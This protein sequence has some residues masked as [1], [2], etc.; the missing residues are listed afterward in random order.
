MFHCTGG[1]LS[2]TGRVW[3]AALWAMPRAAVTG[4]TAAWW[5][6][7]VAD[8][9]DEVEVTVARNRQPGGRPGVRVRRRDLA[10]ADLVLSQFLLVSDVPLT[11]LEAAVQLDADG[12]EF[13]DRALQR[14]VRFEALSRAHHRNLG[15]HGSPAAAALLGAAADGAASLAE[16]RL[17]GLLRARGLTG[18][19]LGYA[20]SGYLLDLAFPAARVAVEVDGWA[21]HSTADRFRADRRRQNAL[22]LAGW[23]VLRFTWDDLVHRPDAVLAQIYAALTA[24]TRRA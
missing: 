20:V 23:T 10:D 8:C 3:A 5:H 1:E 9:P 16:R 2:D 18:W 21:W 13:L 12:P 19:R 17:V 6:G 4:L 7:L 24:P 14:L 22:I 11:V 15:R